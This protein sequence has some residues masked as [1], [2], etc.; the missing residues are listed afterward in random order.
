MSIVAPDVV[1]NYRDKV[2][3]YGYKLCTYPNG[4]FQDWYYLSDSEGYVTMKVS[5]LKFE[6]TLNEYLTG[7]EQVGTNEGEAGL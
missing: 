2:S 6:E 3:K 7:K 5:P 1:E 4:K